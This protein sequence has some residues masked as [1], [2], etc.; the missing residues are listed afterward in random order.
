MPTGAEEALSRPVSSDTIQSAMR[1]PSHAEVL[2]KILKARR[3]VA[4]KDWLGADIGKLLPEFHDLDRWTLEE[5]TEA[6]AAA[7]GEVRSED[8]AGS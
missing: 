3:K 6:L 2:G 5:Q 4:A 8:Y 7:L 1:R